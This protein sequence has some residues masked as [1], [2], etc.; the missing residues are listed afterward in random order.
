[1]SLSWVRL[2]ANIAQHDKILAVL[3]DVS[4]KR[5]QAIASYMFALGWCGAAGTDGWVPTYALKSVH[6]TPSTARL[7]VRY[8]LWIE[9]TDGWRIPN[10][11]QRQEL[12]VI[13]ETK[14][15]AAQIAS[16]KANCTRWHGP[17][18]GCWTEAS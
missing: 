9:G 11:D 5:W 3:D 18:C 6:G 10:Y 13:T 16:R 4:A 15:V 14:R 12:S 1:M 8:S 2:D 7:L 17:T